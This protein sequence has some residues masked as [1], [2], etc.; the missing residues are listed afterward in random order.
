[1]DQ[2]QDAFD[3][4]DDDPHGTTPTGRA[5]AEVAKVLKAQKQATAKDEKQSDAQIA[6]KLEGMMAGMDAA[7]AAEQLEA[8]LQSDPEAVQ[9]V[10]NAQ[11]KAEA[12]ALKKVTAAMQKQ[13]IDSDGEDIPPD[14]TPENVSANAALGI[15]ADGNIAEESLDPAEQETLVKEYMEEWGYTEAQARALAEEDDAAREFDE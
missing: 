6:R 8:G 10:Q 14:Q 15:G 7:D 1:M 5:Q 13:G 9:E 4:T 3:Y 12:R 2:N 11:A